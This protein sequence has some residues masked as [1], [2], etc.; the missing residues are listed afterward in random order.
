MSMA[1]TVGHVSHEERQIDRDDL[2]RIL[3]ETANKLRS[4]FIKSASVAVVAEVEDNG[5]YISRQFVGT[6][7]LIEDKNT[8]YHLGCEIS[9]IDENII[10]GLYT[11]FLEQINLT[12][13]GEEGSSYCLVS[14]SNHPDNL[15]V[16]GI[17]DVCGGSDE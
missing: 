16:L 15:V 6:N 17:A 11:Q 10:G 3:E 9:N 2:A 7:P 14:F 13:S 8:G 5:I 1:I 4:G 12:V